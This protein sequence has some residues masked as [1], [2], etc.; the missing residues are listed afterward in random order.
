MMVALYLVI[1][2]LHSKKPAGDG[3]TRS[4]QGGQQPG[5]R[6]KPGKVMELKLPGKP[7]KVREFHCWSGK[8]NNVTNLR[9]ISVSWQYDVVFFS[10][11]IMHA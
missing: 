11:G 8:M 9:I 2:G 6:G 7:G 1:S 10:D 4:S 5:K 3:S